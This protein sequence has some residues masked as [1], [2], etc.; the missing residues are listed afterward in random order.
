[1]SLKIL[2]TFKRLLRIKEMKKYGK[3]NADMKKINGL[4]F[5]NNT[6]LVSSVYSMAEEKV[7]LVLR[8]NP[9]FIM[10]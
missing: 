6:L 7:T 2:K 9:Q 3:E 5:S 10:K 4:R 8:F 1:V